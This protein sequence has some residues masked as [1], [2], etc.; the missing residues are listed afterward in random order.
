MSIL[1]KLGG[2]ALG[3]L[4]A[5]F[6][7]TQYGKARYGT[8]RADEA[9]AWQAKVVEAERGRLKA[10]QDGLAQRDRAETIYRETIRTLPPITNTIVER[11]TRYAETPAGAAMCLDPIR[12]LGIEQTRATLFPATAAP[13]PT[14]G[15]P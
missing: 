13:A 8:G 2:V 10:F 5:W 12:V 4:A 1:W 7:I 6:L 3:C 15:S 11:A 14:A 9:S